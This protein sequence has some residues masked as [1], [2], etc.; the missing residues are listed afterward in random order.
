MIIEQ[1]V[2]VIIAF[3]IF[4]YMFF[5]MM[6]MSDISYVIVLVLEAIGI[7]LNFL[8]VL[9]RIKLNIVL[10]M[11]KYIFSIII[12]IAI[13]I[14]EKRGKKFAEIFNIFVIKALLKIGNKK[15]AKKML[16]E[17]ASKYP[18]NY[19]AH[20]LLAQIY[21][22]EGGMR[23]AIDEYVQSVELNKRDYDSY[24]RVA[25]LLN[26]LDK[27]DEATQMLFSLLNKKPDYYEA[28]ILL[29]DLL[30]QKEQYKEAERIYQDALRYNPG[31]Y[32]LNY[33]LGIVY[34]MLNDFQNAKTCYEKAAEINSLSYNS[35]YS[36]AEIELIYKNLEEA[37]QRFLEVIEDEVLSADAYYQLA[38]I[39]LIKGDKEKAIQY[40]NIA[41]DID[42]KKIAN[43]I[44]N[45]PLF[46][47]VL[48]KIPI[49]FNLD[50]KDTNEE[51]KEVR[52]LE[53]KEIKAKEHLEDMFEITRNL[54]YNDIKM[55]KKY[56]NEKETEKEEI[57]EEKEQ[58]EKHE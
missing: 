33:N 44:K 43:K 1:L 13:I 58:K 24:Y 22:E 54:S 42:T 25:N 30:I 48:A 55:F 57:Q 56:R 20:R 47:P 27:K 23:K 53:L 29:G 26:C 51:E 38:K 11:L 16:L 8:E 45:D 39:S 5:K 36:L 34:T 4:V 46:I 14:E 21:E 52:K 10:M 15:M 2:F 19:D 28:S 31:S 37:E 9:F 49:P 7:A 35:K 18:E 6:K 3:A 17:I 50:N 12:P 32:D 40:A 41:L